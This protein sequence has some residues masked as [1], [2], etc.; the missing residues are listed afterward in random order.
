MSEIFK[1]IPGY[2]GVYQVSNMG[3]IKCLPIFYTTGYENRA[4]KQKREK[5]MWTGLMKSGYEKICLSGVDGPIKIRKS[6]LV[7]RLVAI[8]FLP[9]IEGLDFINH[10]NGNKTDNRVGNLQW[11]TRSEN[12]QH[13][14]RTGLKV[15]GKGE[16]S[17]N[18]K[19]IILHDLHG[20]TIKRFPCIKDALKTLN[21]SASA[22]QNVLTGK[23]KQTKGYFFSVAS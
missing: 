23:W 22:V 11:C 17:T 6:F 5:I 3:R 21:I 16:Y 14:V 15:S 18:P 19:A 1:D 4:V 13:A 7:H 12:V 20:N 10:K 9:R 2:E 8:A